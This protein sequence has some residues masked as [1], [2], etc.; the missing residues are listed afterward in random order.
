MK[1]TWFLGLFGAM[2]LLVSA[3]APQFGPTTAASTNEPKVELLKPA[4]FAKLKESG[5]GS[6]VVMNFWATWCGP[7][8]AEFHEFVKIDEKYRDKGVKVIGLSADDVTDLKP[9]VVPFLKEK[10][11]KFVNY[12]FDMDDPQQMIDAVNKEWSGALPITLVFDRQ[13]KLAYQRYGII[14]RDQL[15]AAIESAL[16]P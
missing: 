8:V 5:K 3:A 12:V 15:V 11:A 7:C 10:Q 6:V 14:D 16:K 13:G 9:K 1:R 4:N 2:L